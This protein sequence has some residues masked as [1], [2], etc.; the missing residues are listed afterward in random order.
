[1]ESPFGKR[2]IIISRNTYENNKPVVD[3]LMSSSSHYNGGA[4]VD[5]EA[6]FVELEKKMNEH[7][8]YEHKFGKWVAIGMVVF[9]TIFWVWVAFNH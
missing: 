5:D 8:E 6:F 3:K 4:V 7:D 2:I 9:A 1:M